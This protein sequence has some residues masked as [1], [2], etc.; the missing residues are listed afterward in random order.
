M[1]LQDYAG[2]SGDSSPAQVD[3]AILRRSVQ[4]VEALLAVARKIDEELGPDADTLASLF[5]A[6][7]SWSFFGSPEVAAWFLK[8]TI[9]FRKLN[10][11]P[12]HPR[13]ASNSRPVGHRREGVR[14]ECPGK[15]WPRVTLESRRWRQRLS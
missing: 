6:G 11:P 10:E 12:P 9:F 3:A 5:P 15:A 8:V 13:S 4:Q 14:A 2:S 1:D 7:W